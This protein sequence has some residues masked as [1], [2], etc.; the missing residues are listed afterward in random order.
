MK[1][2]PGFYLNTQPVLLS[3]DG[4]VAVASTQA[5]TIAAYIADTA[6]VEAIPATFG[7]TVVDISED[8]SVL[9]VRTADYYQIIRRDGSGSRTLPL[10]TSVT[11]AVLSGDGKVVFAL[12]LGERIVRVDVA[13]GQITDIVPTTYYDM[14]ATWDGV[15][16]TIGQGSLLRLLQTELPGRAATIAQFDEQV[17]PFL[18]PTSVQVPWDFPL[19]R[20]PAS[21]HLVLKPTSAG[22]VFEDAMIFL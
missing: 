16:G 10:D 20:P 7:S 15:T 6:A 11:E 17:W 2:L 4:H 13:T 18:S 9:L 5:R 14:L 19:D 22:N 3:A 8:G 21:L 12:I 1:S